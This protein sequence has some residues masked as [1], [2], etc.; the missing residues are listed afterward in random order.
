VPTLALS[1]AP[2]GRQFLETRNWRWKIWGHRAW[3]FSM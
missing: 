3:K 2:L 1:S